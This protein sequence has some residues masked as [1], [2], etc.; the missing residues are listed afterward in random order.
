LEASSIIAE[1]DLQIS[2]LQQARALLSEA[3]APP[4]VKAR[5][6]RPKGSKNATAKKAT[7]LA[8][9]SAP[10]V[11]KTKRKL[12]PESRKRISDA[13]KLSRANGAKSA[14]KKSAVPETSAK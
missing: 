2:K 13:M 8:K 3:G 4:V 12:S 10:L 11:A 6:G 14:A 9:V 1:I 7:K 5:R